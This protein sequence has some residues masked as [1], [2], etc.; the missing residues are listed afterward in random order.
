[1]SIRAE[2]VLLDWI[3]VNSCLS[4]VRLD[5]S[6]P[7][8]SSQLEHRC[9]LIVSVSVSNECNSTENKDQFYRGCGRSADI[10]V[11]AGD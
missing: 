10:M 1:M 2:R 7:L 4:A 5:G 9:L 6:V 11:I 3:Q 8:S